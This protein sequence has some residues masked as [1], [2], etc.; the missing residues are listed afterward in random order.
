MKT[1]SYNTEVCVTLGDRSRRQDWKLQK[2]QK[3]LAASASYIEQ[4]FS[5]LTKQLVSSKQ[6]TVD[7]VDVNSLMPG[8]N[9]KV[10]HP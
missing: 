9:K 7:A 5:E 6:P 1:K 2:A 4:T 10:T 8:V 3:L